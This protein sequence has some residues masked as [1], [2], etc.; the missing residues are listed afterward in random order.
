MGVIMD[1]FRDLTLEIT[2]H[3]QGNCI[4]CVRDKIRYKLGNMTQQLFE[5]AVT[6]ADELYAKYGGEGRIC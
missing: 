5:K 6:E 3:C 2:T 4:V 1:T